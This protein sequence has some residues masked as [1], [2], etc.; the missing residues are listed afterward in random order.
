MKILRYLIIGLWILLPVVWDSSLSDNYL[1]IRFVWAGIL[2]LVVIGMFWTSKYKSGS[3]ISNTTS[4]D[5]ILGIILVIHWISTCWSINLSE[6]IFNNV[7][8]TLLVA[9]YWITKIWIHQ[10]KEFLSNFKKFTTLQAGIYFVIIFVGVIWMG[11]EYSFSNKDLY[12]LQFPAGH[13]SLISEYI[14]LLLPIVYVVRV[15]HVVKWILL[16]FGIVL[17]LVLQSRAAYLGLTVLIL[18]ALLLQ[19]SDKS[20]I[21]WKFVA[22]IS[23][24]LIMLVI[25]PMI[26]PR[27][28]ILSRLDIRQ[29]AQSETAAHRFQA[30]DKSVQ[31]FRDYPLKGV[32]SGNWKIYLPKYGIEDEWVIPDQDRELIYTR[33]HNDFLEIGCETGIVGILSYLALFIVGIVYAVKLADPEDRIMGLMVVSGLFVISI[34][35]FPKE[36]IEHM[37]LF[38]VILAI[39][40]ARRT[41]WTIEIP[42]KWVGLVSLILITIIIYSRVRYEQELSLKK[43][44]IARAQGMHEDV[45]ENLDQTYSSIYSLDFASIPL[46]WYQGNAHF[47]SERIEQAHSHF[48]GALRD[49]PYH[50]HSL[51]NLGTTYFLQN[52]LDSAIY[53][54]QKTLAIY[55]RFD[56]VK[57]NLSIAFASIEAFDQAQEIL[58]SVKDTNRKFEFLRIIEQKMKDKLSDQ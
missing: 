43:A 41:R 58:N 1:I 31:M 15:N 48:I 2:G 25:I 47:E 16:S 57:F 29:Y 44:L 32:G 21:Q 39:M 50:Y 28:N 20:K 33:T 11:S 55:P 18:I 49:H 10:D 7:R 35:D 8:W 9:V 56:D 17:I 45:I 37:I 30:W 19:F 38:M 40:A 12:R 3:L 14:L 46:K 34:F 53:Y 51:H 27:S 24:G 26:L 5:I 52:N 4:L 6:A 22:T 36:R 13:K 54:Y 42:K 23:L